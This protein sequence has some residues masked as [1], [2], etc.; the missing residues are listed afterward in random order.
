M[1]MQEKK[2]VIRELTEMGKAKGQ[3][4]TKEILDAIGDLDFD[5][6]QLEKIYDSLET[7]GI[8]IVE[9][10]G[11]LPDLSDLEGCTDR[12]SYHVSMDELSMARLGEHSAG[13]AVHTTANALDD[14]DFE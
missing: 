9:D 10:F 3:L 5:A 7:Q 12:R 11:D 1:G 13:S 8:E 4:N 14:L 6:E 2:N